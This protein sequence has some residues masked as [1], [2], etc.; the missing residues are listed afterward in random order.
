MSS[1]QQQHHPSTTTRRRRAVSSPHEEACCGK[2]HSPET[3]PR[4]KPS[5]QHCQHHTLEYGSACS[6]DLSDCELTERMEV[7]IDR[8]F[9]AS[10]S[11][12]PDEAFAIALQKRE[13]AKYK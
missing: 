5:A 12:K 13:I 4:R 2:L 10:Q 1:Q 11:L 3:A 6:G 9:E 8:R 7:H